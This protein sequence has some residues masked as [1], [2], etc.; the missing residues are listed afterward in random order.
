MTFEPSPQDQFSRRLSSITGK[1][2]THADLSNEAWHIEK[3]I[4]IGLIITVVA[5]T[6]GIVWFAATLTSRVSDLERVRI[7]YDNRIK[8]VDG[9]IDKAIEAQTKIDLRLV[10]VEERADSTLAAVNKIDQKVDQLLTLFRT[11]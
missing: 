8:E 11:K 3:K 4:P 10:R 7:V 1:P 6:V 2:E 9:R 5:Q